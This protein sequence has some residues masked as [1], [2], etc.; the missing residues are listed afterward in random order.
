MAHVCTLC[1]SCSHTIRWPHF[2]SLYLAALTPRGPKS[3]GSPSPSTSSSY[4]QKQSVATHTPLRE[5]GGQGSKLPN[6]L[7]RLN[8]IWGQSSSQIK[9]LLPSRPDGFIGHHD[10]KVQSFRSPQNIDTLTLSSTTLPGTSVSVTRNH[11]PIIKSLPEDIVD[12]VDVW[13]NLVIRQS[14]AIQQI[15]LKDAYFH[16]SILLQHR[17]FLRFAFG[18]KAYQYRVL[19]FGL[20]L[21][22]CT[23]TKC[24]DSALAPLRLQGI[25]ILN[26]IHNGLVLAMFQEMVVRQ[27]HVVLDQWSVWGYGSMPK[28]AI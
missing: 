24:I 11:L 17:K 3:K 15:D 20:V 9:R 19:P 21:S 22:Q 4:R 12:L 7:G 13:R 18:G 26:Y 25:C 10:N 14:P 28:R 5:L 27:R 2:I 1:V 8:M 6:L 23:F 16:T